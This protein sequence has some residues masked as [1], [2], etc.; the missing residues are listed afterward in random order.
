MIKMMDNVSQC[1][2]QVILV[3]A[4]AKLL[5]IHVLHEAERSPAIST[6]FA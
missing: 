3:L 1:P 5:H 2:H 6:G 4:L